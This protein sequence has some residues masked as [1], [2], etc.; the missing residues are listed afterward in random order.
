MTFSTLGTDTQ[1]N[2]PL[3]IYQ[4]YRIEG[5]T[6]VGL[7]RMGKSGLFE[8]L[9]L[10]DIKQS[11]SVC[12]LDPHGEL[13]D[14]VIARLPSNREKDAIFLD[15]FDTDYPFGINILECSDPTSDDKISETVNQVT[16][17]FEKAYGISPETPLMYEYL[18]NCAYTLIANPDYTMIDIRPLLTNADF[19]KKL[20]SNVKNADVLDFW[21]RYNRLRPTD[22]DEKS[23]HIINKLIDF[24]HAP[25]RNIVGQSRSTID[26]QKIMDSGKILLVKLD[27]KREQVT[28]LIGSILVALILNASDTRNPKMP[29]HLYADEFQNFATEDFAVLLEQAGKRN[30]GI[31]MAFQNLSQLELSNKQADK[32]LKD[33]TLS[34]GSLVVFRSPT[35]A[36]EL[37][38]KFDTSPQPAWEQELEPE[39]IKILKPQWHERKEEV[40][41]D[42]A[43]EIKT[44]TQKPVDFIVSGKSHTSAVV[45]TVLGKWK[46]VV[47]RANEPIRDI[48]IFTGIWK[49]T[50]YYD[51]VS[52]EPIIRQAQH[53]LQ[54]INDLLYQVMLKKNPRQVV[55]IALVFMMA[56]TF[57]LTFFDNGR[58]TQME[59]YLHEKKMHE[60]KWGETKYCEKRFCK[61]DCGKNHCSFGSIG[62]PKKNLPW[63][64]GTLPCH[65][66]ADFYPLRDYFSFLLETIAWGE[67]RKPTD[68]D[69]DVYIKL[70]TVP[71]SELE[72]ALS[73]YE[74]RVRALLR[75][76]LLLPL[77][78]FR[79]NCFVEGFS[80]LAYT[81]RHE[82]NQDQ[83]DPSHITWGAYRIQDLKKQ[84]GLEWLELDLTALRW[85]KVNMTSEP[86]SKLE[87]YD[88]TMKLPPPGD[89]RRMLI[90]SLPDIDMTKYSWKWVP[91]PGQDDFWKNAE[92]LL[93]QVIEKIITE[94]K[95][96]FETLVRE[97]REVMQALA[98]EPITLT[99]G[100]SQPRK[101]TQVTYITH[102]SEKLTIPRKTILHPQRTHADMLNDIAN[103]LRGLPRFTARVKLT[104]VSDTIVE[105]TLTTR[106]PEK[107]VYGRLLEDRF[108][109]IKLHTRTAGYTRPRQDVEVEIR[110]RQDALRQTQQP[111]VQKVPQ[112]LQ[113][114]RRYPVEHET[115]QSLAANDSQLE[116]ELMELWRKARD[117]R[118]TSLEF[119]EWCEQEAQ[120]IGWL[121]KI[122]GN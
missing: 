78:Y 1:T 81:W 60:I 17:V 39:K 15:I 64:V 112:P 75:R 12:V 69:I 13:I 77:S 97:L 114:Q 113:R 22:Q 42:G 35:N 62:S 44:P 61:G 79:E 83:P 89:A 108:E 107:G 6:V 53:E 30:I 99:S 41:E 109:R 16:H 106:E 92:P 118:L 50:K 86:L 18:Y 48:R 54:L 100:L 46:G 122:L 34:V 23:S 33:R 105:Y 47:E 101:R 56:K 28:S 52:N 63:Y 115:V 9:I 36:D 103:Q 43:E 57:G 58:Y 66:L 74:Q 71:D 88:N 37:A 68:E 67:E 25:L 65:H 117:K 120:L 24:S 93:Q 7:Q 51:F 59:E 49:N 38:E 85:Q 104:D 4:K 73:A 31:A 40:I 90:N 121:K 29:F 82:I 80:G 19:R 32:N 11:I 111:L 26:L 87:Y 45:N 84:C 116:Q 95:T 91:V 55:P 10:S 72:Q 94:Q 21:D 110:M 76:D 98:K 2:Q 119:K 14:H 27:R 8:E 5:L 3:L 20:V 96:T 70:W 102:E